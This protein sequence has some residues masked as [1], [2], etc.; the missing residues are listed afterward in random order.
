MHVY[1]PPLRSIGYYEVVDGLDRRH[2]ECRVTI[3]G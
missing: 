2:A 1:S 3:A